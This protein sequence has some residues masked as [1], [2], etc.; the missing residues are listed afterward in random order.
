MYLK[1]I[2]KLCITIISLSQLSAQCID[3][4]LINP[5]GNCA[6]V[7]DPVCGCN[8]KTYNNFC[9]AENIDGI[10]SSSPGICA[11]DQTDIICIGSMLPI[12]VTRNKLNT[13]SWNPSDNLSCVDCSLTIANPTYSTLYELTTTDAD[14]TLSFTYFE[15]LV[16]N[17]PAQTDTIC[18]GANIPIGLAPDKSNTY[19][20]SPNDNLSCI[21]CSNP[22]ASPTSST[23]YELTITNPSGNSTLSYFEVFVETCPTQPIQIDTI[24]LGANVP[25]GVT[26]NKLSTY[27]WNPTDNLSC[28]NCAITIASPISSIL[29]ELTTTDE[30]G[31]E[32]FTYF[33][34]IVETCPPDPIEP[35]QIDTIC[36]GANVQIGLA[37]DNSN[38]YSW[39]PSNNL[40]CIDCANPMASP[41]SSTLYELTTTDLS[42]NSTLSYFDI[43]VEQCS[44][45]E[46]N[47]GF[48]YQ[49]NDIVKTG[50]DPATQIDLI[51]D[52]TQIIQTDNACIWNWDF[53][54][55]NTSTDRNPTGILFSTLKDGL[56][57]NLPY[58]VCLSVFD[59]SNQLI[60]TCCQ[61]IGPFTDCQ[62]G[63]LINAV[64]N[65][66]TTVDPICGCNNKSYP[67][68]CTAINEDGIHNWT[69]LPCSIDTEY[70]IC[71]GEAIRIGS[72][73]FTSGV[74]Y[75]WFPTNSL[76]CA[77]N[78]FQTTASPNQSTLYQLTTSNN[79]TGEKT[80]NYY[81]VNVLDEVFCCSSNNLSWLNTL[82]D[83]DFCNDCYAE[84]KQVEIDGL[85]YIYF[86]KDSISCPNAKS[87]L[88]YCNGNTFCKEDAN[89]FCLDTLSFTIT[90]NIW[91]KDAFCDLCET[92][93]VNSIS[94]LYNTYGNGDYEVSRYSYNSSTTLYIEKCNT[95][96]ADTINRMLVNCSNDLICAWDGFTPV[97]D[98]GNCNSFFVEGTFVEQLINC[99]CFDPS[100]INPDRNCSSFNAPVC[101]CDGRTYNNFCIGQRVAGITSWTT[102]ACSN[103][104]N[105]VDT[106][107]VF[108]GFLESQKLKAK[109]VIQIG[110]PLI[111]NNA[112]ILEAEQ[113]IDLLNG[114]ECPPNAT[115]E[116]NNKICY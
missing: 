87:S 22:M 47:D 39:N 31:A 68:I 19:T 97:I 41:T 86:E 61:P 33:D 75:S 9:T 91:S 104:S 52:F 35:T 112:L 103:N 51:V 114:F 95:T 56:P 88:T 70:Q 18:L 7:Y 53:D 14:G 67:N 63:T 45:C 6:A 105:C 11:V 16:E 64:Q 96:A 62:D 58:D 43:I 3:V 106:I 79:T 85:N 27:T 5:D 72:D 71:E 82:L 113:S 55:G 109:Q 54:N 8:G 93:D 65:C 38:T 66:N 74:Q 115:I 29:Y 4:T 48:V 94:W 25:I 2:L 40:S 23:L 101:G 102:G 36:L 34:V 81:K 20:W 15:I 76:S 69:D 77:N 80:Y 1:C 42:G 26:N 30:T 28:T 46:N 24:C 83:D 89:G 17:C 37:P 59:C 12:G 13:Y 92:T 100:L 99:G 21:D 73:I 50:N 84:V 116:I 32:S 10:T 44:L 110:A 57:I 111:G 107:Q 49:I 90:E 108:N 60:E 78:C 98:S